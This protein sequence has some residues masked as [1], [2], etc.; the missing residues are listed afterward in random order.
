MNTWKKLLNRIVNIFRR[1]KPPA[2]YKVAVFDTFAYACPFYTS[3]YHVNNWYGCSHP[4]QE[5]TD[6]DENGVERGKCYNSSCPLGF[7]PY[8]EDWNNPEVDWDDT[9]LGDILI[10]GRWPEGGDNEHI[11]VDVGPDATEDERRAWQCYE[12]RINRYNPDWPGW[13]KKGVS[14]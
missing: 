7:T 9:T 5:E 6:P 3:E 11:I 8:E 12:R 1:S 4:D 14:E 10:D 13:E 2:R